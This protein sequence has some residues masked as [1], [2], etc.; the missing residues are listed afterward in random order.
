[1]GRAKK[2][3]EQKLAL[4]RKAV[5]IHGV[6]YILEQL[7]LTPAELKILLVLELNSDLLGSLDSEETELVVQNS[8]LRAKNL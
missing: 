3:N 7:D 5:E 6:D 4:L 1:M 8:S 2:I